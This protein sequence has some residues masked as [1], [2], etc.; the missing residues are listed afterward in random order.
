MNEEDEESEEEKALV[1][2][3][4]SVNG[5]AKAIEAA[6]AKNQKA[7]KTLQKQ[8]AMVASRLN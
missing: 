5:K 6:Y 2:Q 3:K 7:M 1:G 4:S 8:L